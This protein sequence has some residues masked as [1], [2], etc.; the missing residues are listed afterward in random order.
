MFDQLSET[1]LMETAPRLC[2]IA[3]RMRPVTLSCCR[4]MAAANMG[5]RLV[6][7]L[8]QFVMSDT[9]THTPPQTKKPT[10]TTTHESYNQCW[11][12]AVTCTH[13]VK[14]VSNGFVIDIKRVCAKFEP[15]RHAAMLGGDRA[16]CAL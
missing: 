16:A 15:L 1:S 6:S 13:T 8:K 5:A 9:H 12:P 7:R 14:Q 4:G 3:S 10:R 2:V 11:C